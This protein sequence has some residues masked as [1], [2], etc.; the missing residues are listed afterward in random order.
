MIGYLLSKT[1]DKLGSPEKP[2]SDLGLLSYR[3]YWKSAIVS[4]LLSLSIN[5]TAISI[6]DLSNETRMVHDDVL[7]TLKLLNAIR[8]C[9]NG[10]YVIFLDKVALQTYVEKVASKGYLTINESNLKWDPVL[11]NRMIT[12][13]ATLEESN[14]SPQDMVE[15]ER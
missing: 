5:S 7:Y 9:P 8:K 3:N 6:A 1:E 10:Q 13:T 12:N 14:E 11:F 15:M 4:A 2:L